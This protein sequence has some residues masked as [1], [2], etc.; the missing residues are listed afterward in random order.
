MLD[1]WCADPH[2]HFFG[3]ALTEQIAYMGRRS[4]ADDTIVHYYQTLTL[5]HIHESIELL[6][7][8]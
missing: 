3:T 5:D 8:S 4:T 6:A 2:V 1:G 7:H